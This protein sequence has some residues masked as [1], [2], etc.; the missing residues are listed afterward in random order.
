MTNNNFYKNLSLIIIS[1]VLISTIGFY[2]LFT[3]KIWPFNNGET[4]VSEIILFNDF[5]EK[6]TNIYYDLKKETNKH[7]VK[8]Q[9][10]SIMLILRSLTGD[11]SNELYKYLKELNVKDL[12]GFK[13]FVIYLKAK[14]ILEN[15]KDKIFK[16]LQYFIDE[17]IKIY[18]GE[19]NNENYLKVS[20]NEQDDESSNIYFSSIDNTAEDS[21]SLENKTDFIKFKNTNKRNNEIEQNGDTSQN[22]K[23]FWEKDSVNLVNKEIS[24]KFIKR[25]LSLNADKD[26]KFLDEVNKK[27]KNSSS[28]LETIFVKFLNRQFYCESIN[29]ELSKLIPGYIERKGN[30]FLV[31]EDLMDDNISLITSKEEKNVN[32]IRKDNIVKK[33]DLNIEKNKSDVIEKNNED[34]NSKINEEVQKL[35][36][37]EQKALENVKNPNFVIVKNNQGQDSNVVH[38]D[39]NLKEENKNKDLTP[40]LSPDNK[41]TGSD[42]SFSIA[43]YDELK[44]IAIGLSKEQISLPM[45]KENIGSK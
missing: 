45:P 35:I 17:K 21:V 18:K 7:N 37:T 44:E 28:I 43:S 13:N 9:C 8:L 11:K 19:K 16:I 6:G 4:E 27:E 15:D 30:P 26:N 2:L 25:I 33:K 20:E 24:E 22:V 40:E 5:I 29:D 42:S 3:Y 31:D 34:Q 23:K 36:D 38:P 14:L 10:Y 12:N 41:S 1:V 32:K 39:N